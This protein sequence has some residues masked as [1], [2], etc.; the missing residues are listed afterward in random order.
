[1]KNIFISLINFNGRQNTIDCLES[2]EKLNSAGPKLNV[3][4]IDNNSKE[5]F[6]IR[7]LRFKNQIKI[8]RNEQNLG[9]SGGH[10]VG[11]DFALSKD[12]DYILILNNDTIVDSNLVQEL[13]RELEKN[14]KVGIATPKIYF[15]P[16]FEFHKDRYKKDELGRVIWYAGGQIDWN[17]II[18]KHTGVDEVDNGQYNHIL[19]TEFASGACMLIKREL[20]EKIGKFDEKYFL[21]YEDADFCQRSKKTGYKTI[22]APRAILWHKNAGSA[23]GSG[24]EL[25]DYY[26]TRNRLLFGMKYAPYRSKLALLKE[27]IILL[28]KGRKWQKK[29]V[30]DF[31]SGKFGKGSFQYE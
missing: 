23:G 4:V 2:I 27:S 17:N 26:L 22:Y 15:F 8:I 14:S 5:K 13:L 7:D 21:Y 11:I 29:G 25:Q 24:S 30:R 12:A 31:Y 16:G 3:V 9:F 19:E 20:I 10:N 1:M 28:T 18:G 6:T